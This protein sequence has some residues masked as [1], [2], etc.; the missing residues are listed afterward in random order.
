MD[1]PHAMRAQRSETNEEGQ[2][3]PREGSADPVQR[4]VRTEKSWT[5]KPDA[6]RSTR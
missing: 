6:D 1:A 2:I 3:I 5:Q 4:A